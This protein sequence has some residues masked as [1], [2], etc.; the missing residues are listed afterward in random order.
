MRTCPVLVRYKNLLSKVASERVAL[1]RRLSKI[2]LRLLHNRFTKLAII[3]F[4]LFS[5]SGYYPTFSIPP[6]RKAVVAA[7]NQQQKGEIIA[8]NFSKP[9]ILPHPGYLST[10][11]SPYHPG[12]DIAAGLGMPI[13]PITDG[14]VA[15]V[16][17]DL[18]GLGNFVEVVH[19]NG[20]KSKY[21][22]MG[23]TYVKVGQKITAENTLGEV[24]LTGH[25]SGPHTHLEVTREGKFIDPQAL[26]PEIPDM[27]ASPRGE[28][29]VA[30]KR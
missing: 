9:P 27:P 30:V 16:G 29:A 18:F 1:T 7:S 4:F 24:G 10:R 6:V 28:P 8:Q 14:E 25:T 13:H 12:I 11:F 26:L 17:R 3:L 22:H 19:Q 5:L 15:I 20:F 2:K 23:K 21:A